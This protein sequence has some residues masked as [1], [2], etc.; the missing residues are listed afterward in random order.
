MIRLW[1]AS[2]CKTWFFADTYNT[3]YQW[4]DKKHEPREILSFKHKVSAIKEM[5]NMDSIAIASF[6]KSITLWHIS[7]GYILSTI[8]LVD[9]SAHTLT[10]SMKLCLLFT[11]SFESL[12]RVFSVD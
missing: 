9:S 3:L 2:Y 10:Y 4:D 8:N 11:A 7:R 6:N 1:Y 12:V 5:P